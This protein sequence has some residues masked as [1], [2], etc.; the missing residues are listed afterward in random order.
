MRAVI[1]ILDDITETSMPFN[2]FVLY[3][4]KKYINEKQIVIVCNNRQTEYDIYDNVKLVYTGRRITAI[5]TAIKKEVNKLNDEG[6]EFVIHIHQVQ[7]GILFIFASFML[8]LRRKTLFTVHSTFSGYKIHN[9]ILSFINAFFAERISCVSH[10]SYEDYPSII[11]RIKSNRIVEVQ[12]GVDTDRINS[13][14]IKHVKHEEIVF[15]YVARQV[16]IKN[17]KFLVKIINQCPDNIRFVFVGSEDKEKSV[18]RLAEALGCIKKI[19]FTGLIPREKVFE[20][21]M[22]ADF[23]IS[24]SK[25]EGL[26]ISV[27]EAMY[28]GLPCLLSDIPQH[29]ECAGDV[30]IC[31]PLEERVWREQIVEMATMRYEGRKLLMKKTHDYVLEQFTLSKMHKKYDEIYETL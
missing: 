2:E 20:E 25:L 24:P 28:C 11:K 23:Y 26:P 21:L 17:H 12:N 29:R 15:I 22:N 1:T 5:R 9:K 8:G 19:R 18:R 10:V 7:S 27:L 3:R 31:I 6:I 16:P 13:L 30:A 4:S 14:N